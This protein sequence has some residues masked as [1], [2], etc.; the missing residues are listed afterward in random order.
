MRR[1]WMWACG[2]VW[3]CKYYWLCWRALQVEARGGQLWRLSKTNLWRYRVMSK[4]YF[5][6]IYLVVFLAIWGTWWNLQSSPS[7]SL[8]YS[9][10]CGQRNLKKTEVAALWKSPKGSFMWLSLF[11]VE[12]V[13]SQPGEMSSAKTIAPNNN[14]ASQ[15]LKKLSYQEI[16]ERREKTAPF[17]VVVRSTLLGTN[18]RIRECFD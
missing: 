9:R 14:I 18:A 7:A 12:G 4:G 2:Y 15:S 13:T 8:A 3:F 1:V 6:S 5:K 11:N 10:H 17:S 16:R